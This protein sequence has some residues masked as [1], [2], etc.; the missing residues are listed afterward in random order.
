MN[1]RYLSLALAS[2]LALYGCGGGSDGGNKNSSVTP[3]TPVIPTT[4]PDKVEPQVPDVTFSN[5][6]A[7]EDDED[8]DQYIRAPARFDNETGK[9]Y[10]VLPISGTHLGNLYNADSIET[11]RIFYPESD[12]YVTVNKGNLATMASFEDLLQDKN[13]SLPDIFNMLSGNLVDTSSNS[14]KLYK[15]KR[16]AE[17]LRYT[18]SRALT[19]GEQELSMQSQ[20]LSNFINHLNNNPLCKEDTV[21]LAANLPEDKSKAL[22]ALGVTIEPYLTQEIAWGKTMAWIGVAYSDD[23]LGTT[24]SVQQI[25]DELSRKGIHHIGL[26]SA[27]GGTNDK[28]ML[29]SLTEVDVVLGNLDTSANET[30][31]SELKTNL[32]Q[33]LDS[34][35]FE[36]MNRGG[37]KVCM[38]Y[39]SNKIL[40]S[41]SYEA[42]TNIK[43][44]V[45]QC[46]G[47]VYLYIDKPDTRYNEEVYSYSEFYEYIKGLNNALDNFGS[48]KEFY[49]V[50]KLESTGI[51]EIR[52]IEKKYPLN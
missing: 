1:K 32:N 30:D 10:K 36:T 6:M 41:S 23:V 13:P 14:Y 31:F 28:V 19:L 18:C 25:I 11:T 50:S 52:K 38:S 29:N 48:D 24:N 12:S 45:T 7:A 27:M 8:V 33:K 3:E 44:E 4:K 43:G 40:T 35:K 26:L 47:S 46:E 9:M 15:G 49:I 2:M 5:E 39:N 16:E 37:Q 20:D 17:F 22:K 34:Y 21:V 42:E 51:E